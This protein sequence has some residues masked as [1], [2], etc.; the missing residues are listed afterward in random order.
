M[1]ASRTARAMPA[2]YVTSFARPA[3]ALR[4]TCAGEFYAP[5]P[6]A[7]QLA[8]LA[9]ACISGDLETVKL[10]WKPH[11][12]DAVRRLGRD[13]TGQPLLHAAHHLRVEVVDFLLQQ[14]M[15]PRQRGTVHPY[16]GDCMTVAET[17][18][19]W[20]TAQRPAGACAH[21][22]AASSTLLCAQV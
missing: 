13:D 7:P 16:T 1:Q 19:G 17:Q 21:Q 3:R 15:S 11:M 8:P 14:G 10:L 4:S 22:P 5:K 18:G 12:L 20:R 9:A 6:V 2:A